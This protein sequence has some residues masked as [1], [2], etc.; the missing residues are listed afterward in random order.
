MDDEREREREREMRK[1]SV[2][3]I[4]VLDLN[5]TDGNRLMKR[6]VSLKYFIDGKYVYKNDSGENFIFQKIKI[7][8]N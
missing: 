3:R 7:K 6:I 5:I 4:L 8:N 1:K 2:I